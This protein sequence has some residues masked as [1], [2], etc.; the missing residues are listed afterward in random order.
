MNFEL[1]SLPKPNLKL[2]PEVRQKIATKFRKSQVRETVANKPY[3]DRSLRFWLFFDQLYFNPCL[4]KKKL[5]RFRYL[6][7]M[8]GY[9]TLI[10]SYFLNSA[11]SELAMS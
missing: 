1:K 3:K 5:V 10:R 9:N 2:A 11:T 4:A 6:F 7:K 8:N